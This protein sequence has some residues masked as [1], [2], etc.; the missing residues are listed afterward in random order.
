MSM[1]SSLGCR[2][3]VHAVSMVLPG[4][5]W[6]AYVALSL[7]GVLRPQPGSDN[8]TGKVLQRM[9]CSMRHR[10]A[11]AVP[12]AHLQRSNPRPGVGH[13]PLNRASAQWSRADQP[14]QCRHARVL[15]RPRHDEVEPIAPAD[16]MTTRYAESWAAPAFAGWP[17]SMWAV[18]CLGLPTKGCKR[19]IAQCVPQ[20]GAHGSS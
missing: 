12:V 2:C 7:S 9:C 10:A 4:C 8:T 11:T 1:G 6:P 16:R 18:R 14:A 13:L 20:P 5:R 19:S 17:P 3:T 15:P